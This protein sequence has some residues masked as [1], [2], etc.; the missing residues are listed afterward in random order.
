MHA[1]HPS[2]SWPINLMVRKA[3]MKWGVALAHS[4]LPWTSDHLQSSLLPFLGLWAVPYCCDTFSSYSVAVPI[5]RAS[6]GLSCVPWNKCFIFQLYYTI[7][8]L[9]MVHKPFTIK[10]TQKWNVVKALDRPSML[11]TIHG[12]LALL[13]LKIILTNQLRFLIVPLSY[14]CPTHLLKA[15][16]LIAAS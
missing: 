2:K 7:C 9:T 8:H 12:Q 16:T 1:G 10:A 15:V 6:S 13:S 4:W 5:R 11:P 14:S 3:T